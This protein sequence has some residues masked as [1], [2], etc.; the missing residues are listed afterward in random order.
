MTKEEVF[1]KLQEILSGEF[2]IEASSITP[3]SKLYED[4]ELDSIDAVDLIVKMK[5][6]IPG[7][8]DPEPFKKAKTI[9]DVVDILHP[10]IQKTDG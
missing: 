6:Y 7:K 10:L 5:E 8:I 2:E 3:E 1:L 9:Q 4:L